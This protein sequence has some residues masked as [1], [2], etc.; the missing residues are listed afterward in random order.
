MGC[1]RFTFPVPKTISMSP[2]DI[3]VLI[4]R[5]YEHIA[6][7]GQKDLEHMIKNLEKEDVILNYVCGPNVITNI[8]MRGRQDDQS[9]KK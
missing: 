4:L 3:K 9:Q 1:T 5:N 6:L 7:Q 8:L 2:N